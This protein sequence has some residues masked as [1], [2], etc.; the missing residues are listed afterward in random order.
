MG[1]SREHV[2]ARGLTSLATLLGAALVVVLPSLLIGPP[3]ATAIA[4]LAVLLLGVAVLGQ[5]EL[6]AASRTM[7]TF[8]PRPH[9]EPV[10]SLPGR[11]TDPVHHP[12]RPRAP[13]SA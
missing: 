12:L 3:D 9:G 11:A 10:P 6:R 13:G 5:L 8:E 7:R 4:A 1:R 2:N